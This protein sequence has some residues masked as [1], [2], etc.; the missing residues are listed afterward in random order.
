MRLSEEA[1]S[2]AAEAAL[3]APPLSRVVTGIA[4]AHGLAACLSLGNAITEVVD[5]STEVAP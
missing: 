1:L 5:G 2:S 3:A 4:A